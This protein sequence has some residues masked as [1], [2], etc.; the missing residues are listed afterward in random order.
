MALAHPQGSFTNNPVVSAI[1]ARLTTVENATYLTS[2][3][4]N[5]LAQA[6]DVTAIDNR[7]Q[8]LEATQVVEQADF[9]PVSD[10]ADE[11]NDRLAQNRDAIIALNN[12]LTA[13]LATG[14]FTNADGTNITFTAIT[15]AAMDATPPAQ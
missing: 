11:N 4:L 15:P 12:A 10:K 14:T 6:S 2:A 9:D 3:D 8:V 7:V 1:D 5:G 13:L